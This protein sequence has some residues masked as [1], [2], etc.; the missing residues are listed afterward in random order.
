[1]ISSLLSLR[2]HVLFARHRDYPPETNGG[3]DPLLGEGVRDSER[4]VEEGGFPATHPENVHE[5]LQFFT[6]GI[7]SLKLLR[8][9]TSYK[10][11]LS[12]CLTS[13]SSSSLIQ[14]GVCGCEDGYTEV[15]T[16]DGVLDQCTVIPVLEIPTAGDNRA[17]V[18][19]IRGFNPT[20]PEASSPGRGGRTW[21]LQPFGPEH[22]IIANSAIKEGG[23][24][25][26]V[27]GGRME[28]R[29]KN[30]KREIM[31]KEVERR[32]NENEVER[33]RKSRITTKE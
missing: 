25:I 33:G 26:R 22:K 3:G 21:F 31:G 29:R 7:T 18:K 2:L 13:L 15:M 19:T 9:F 11:V 32:E 1:M 14:A 24:V 20:L 6:K 12:L 28:G 23:G 10:S 17:D 16:S 5:C 27:K 4:V 30:T 8:C